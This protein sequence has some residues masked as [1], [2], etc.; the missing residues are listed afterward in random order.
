[1]NIQIRCRSTGNKRHARVSSKPHYSTD[2]VA[3]YKTQKQIVPKTGLPVRAFRSLRPIQ[4]TQSAIFVRQSASRSQPV[5]Q[6]NPP[7]ASPFQFHHNVN[8][9]GTTKLSLSGGARSA[10]KLRK[11]VWSYQPFRGFVR[12]RHASVEREAVHMR[13]P[14]GCQ[15]R[16]STFFEKTATFFR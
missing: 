4:A 11:K 1:M 8:Q 5:R 12:L 13:H 10:P 6:T 16:F 3:C 2:C 9:R 14:R 7:P 15:A